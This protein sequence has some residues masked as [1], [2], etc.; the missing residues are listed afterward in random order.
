[1]SPKCFWTCLARST[2]SKQT[3]FNMIVYCKHCVM[4]TQ[5]ELYFALLKDV[6]TMLLAYRRAA[7]KL[8]NRSTDSQK[9]ATG[10]AVCHCRPFKWPDRYLQRNRR[11]FCQY[12]WPSGLR[13]GSAADRLLGL[14]VRIP[15]GAWMFVLCVL[16]TKDR[17]QNAGQSGQRNKYG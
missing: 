15:P 10:W 1:M 3:P 9:V 14:R 12:Q 7:L 5:F 11:F 13:R 16:Y 2:R 4:Q 8:F 6:V 17:R